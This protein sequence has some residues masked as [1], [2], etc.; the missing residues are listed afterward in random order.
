MAHGLALGLIA[1]Q[2]AKLAVDHV[3]LFAT[4]FSVPAA[5]PTGH[6]VASRMTYG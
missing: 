4:S 2:A 5:T 1:E 3:P 6:S